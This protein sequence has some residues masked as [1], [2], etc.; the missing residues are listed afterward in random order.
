MR[1]TLLLLWLSCLLGSSQAGRLKILKKLQSVSIKAASASEQ[2]KAMATVTAGGEPAQENFFQAMQSAAANRKVQ[3][4]PTFSSGTLARQP[5][6]VS[7]TSTY[8]D[9]NAMIAIVASIAVIAVLAAA[10]YSLRGYVRSGGNAEGAD[11]ALPTAGQKARPKGL[12]SLKPKGDAEAVV[13]S[14]GRLQ[15]ARSANANAN[16]NKILVPQD[17]QVDTGRSVS[18]D[19]Q[20]FFT[21]TDIDLVSPGKGKYTS[22]RI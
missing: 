5:E 7:E 1:T 19:K 9:S 21:L 2:R 16:S 4:A 14:S 8:I 13:P 3:S 20:D 17:S 6:P 11:G 18:N 10:I 15:G 12:D 22:P